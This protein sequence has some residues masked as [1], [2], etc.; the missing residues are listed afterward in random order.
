MGLF[1]GHTCHLVSHAVRICVIDNCA[2]ERAAQRICP[3]NFLERF[4]PASTQYAYAATHTN[5][6][7]HNFN[8]S[9]FHHTAPT[10]DLITI[11]SSTYVR[12]LEARQIGYAA[13]FFYGGTQT[14]DLKKKFLPMIKRINEVTLAP[15]HRHLYVCR[16]CS[17]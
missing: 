10:N 9:I 14:L 15:G 16:T 3:G 4:A 7:T 6:M 5:E 12:V 2:N 1:R 13:V 8:Y 17:Q 11:R